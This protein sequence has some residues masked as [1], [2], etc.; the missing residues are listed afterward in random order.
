MQIN[1][2]VHNTEKKQ[3]NVMNNNP[4]R[5]GSRKEMCMNA[6]ARTTS[7]AALVTLCL[8]LAAQ[9]REDAG[10]AVPDRAALDRD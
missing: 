5:R 9:A 4:N 2:T 6:I 3:G 1:S 8:A 10:P 7:V